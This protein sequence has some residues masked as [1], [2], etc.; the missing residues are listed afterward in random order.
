M[1]EYIFFDQRARD[2][3]VRFVQEK[4]LDPVC[5]A[6]DE[7]WKVLLP[8]GLQDELSERVEARYDEMMALVRPCSRVRGGRRSSA[9][10]RPGSPWH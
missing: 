2:G 6:D 10:T 4:G 5:E 7:V 3:F 1:L 8:E 9:I